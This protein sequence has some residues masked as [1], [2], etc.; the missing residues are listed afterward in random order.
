MGWREAGAAPGDDGNGPGVDGDG[1]SH[2]PAPS[3]SSGDSDLS[4]QNISQ[5]RS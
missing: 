2:P 1:V 4:F 3:S 5:R